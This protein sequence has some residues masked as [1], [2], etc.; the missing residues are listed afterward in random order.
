MTAFRFRFALLALLGI[1]VAAP[2]AQAQDRDPRD[3]H[4]KLTEVLAP[5]PGRGLCFA[6]SYGAAHLRSHDKQKV[7]SIAFVLK[8]QKLEAGAII[9]YG[10]GDDDKQYQR[11]YRYDYGLLVRMRHLK[12]NL[13]ASGECNSAEAIGCSVDCDGGSVWIEKAADGRAILLR[14]ND[15]RGIRMTMGCGGEGG[16]MMFAPGEDDREFRLEP[17]QSAVCRALA[18]RTVEKRVGRGR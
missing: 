9:E 1:G 7:T 8:F 4:T 11:D 12:S 17:Q 3:T 5:V 18:R 14:P 6:R 13:Y 2:S 15:P 16:S 10:D